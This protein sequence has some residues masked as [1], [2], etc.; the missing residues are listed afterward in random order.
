M[1]DD[2][3]ALRASFG[4]DLL[5][6]WI[7]DALGAADALRDL[8][9]GRVPPPAALD[10]GWLRVPLARRTE[11][12]P[13]VPVAVR[14]HLHRVVERA[15]SGFEPTAEVFSYR[16]LTWN[17]RTAFGARGARL[18][19]LAERG[20]LPLV[21]SLDVHRFGRSLPLATLL[22]AAWMTEELATDLTRLTAEAGHC[23]LSSHHWANRLGGAALAPVDAVLGRLVPGQWLRWADDWHVFVRDADEAERVRAAVR[24][25][26]AALG[27]TLSA[28]KSGLRP[29][30]TVRTGPAR[31]VAGESAQV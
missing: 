19:A 6:E 20:D 25:G 2:A 17:Y 3:P 15:L 18:R 23:L 11:A 31:D 5:T 8:A 27:L 22:D 30:A 28:N 10:V 14:A 26:L 12:V 13:V 7:P 21:L 16:A 9:R 4:H 24:D 29:A 1:T